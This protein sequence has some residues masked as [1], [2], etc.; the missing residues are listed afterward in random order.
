VF[1]HTF[2]DSTKAA[3]GVR[4]VAC[5]DLREIA[6]SRAKTN[7]G[8]FAA[9]VW[10]HDSGEAKPITSKTGAGAR[11]QPYTL[12]KVVFCSSCLDRVLSDH[13]TLCRNPLRQDFA[14]TTIQRGQAGPLVRISKRDLLEANT[15]AT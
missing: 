3:F 9:G 11:A 10:P 7:L 8:Y 14:D 13:P 6:R 5:N 1:P 12:A 4:A 2:D 15:I